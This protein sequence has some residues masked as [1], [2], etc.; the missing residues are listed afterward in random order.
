MAAALAASGMLPTAGELLAVPGRWGRG[1]S[2]VQPAFGTRLWGSGG[3]P[4]RGYIRVPGILLDFSRV[5]VELESTLADRSARPQLSAG[6]LSF[7]RMWPSIEPGPELYAAAP[8]FGP[9]TVPA[10]LLLGMAF[11]SS[12]SEEL[13]TIRFKAFAGS[14]AVNV[15]TL[16]RHAFWGW[17]S[18]RLKPS[19][20]HR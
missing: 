1:W 11:L 14:S 17:P 7:L 15:C 8:A 10:V 3:G 20:H 2:W 6:A 19:Q 9:R 5:H 13:E 4:W 18:V 16:R 12:C